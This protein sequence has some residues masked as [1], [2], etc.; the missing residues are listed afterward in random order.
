MQI[1]IAPCQRINF[2]VINDGISVK[3]VTTTHIEIS[4]NDWSQLSGI[5]PPEISVASGKIK[6]KSITFAPII[7][8]NETDDCFLEK[9]VIAVANSGN[10]VPS[11]ITVVETILSVMPTFNA[12]SPAL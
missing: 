6:L 5:T 3:S 8:P 11:A 4:I 7:L 9:A 2:L 1:R 10:D 12:I